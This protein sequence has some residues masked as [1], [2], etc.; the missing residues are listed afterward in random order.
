MDTA[1]KDKKI[2]MPLLLLWGARGHSPECAK[3]FL[4]VWRR[5][6]SNIVAHEA[7]ECGHYIQEKVPDRVFQHF[8]SFF[9]V[10]WA[11]Q[12]RTRAPVRRWRWCRASGR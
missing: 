10:F 2:D 8:T 4:D 7:I 3:E 1:D 9:K 12:R 11:S 5:Y 6:A